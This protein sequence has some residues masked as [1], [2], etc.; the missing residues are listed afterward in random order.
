MLIT[1]ILVITKIVNR[2]LHER[3]EILFLCR[4]NPEI[5]VDHIE[6]LETE[7]ND[8]KEEVR[9]KALLNQNTFDS[10]HE[11]VNH[12]LCKCKYCGYSLQEDSFNAALQGVP[13]ILDNYDNLCY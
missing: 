7:L 11:I 6:S 13:P 5:I 2:I 8:V 10:P 1:F 12:R 3:E 4:S 9:I